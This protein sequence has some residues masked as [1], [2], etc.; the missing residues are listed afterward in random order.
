MPR[1]G[2][3]HPPRLSGPGTFCSRVHSCQSNRSHSFNNIVMKSASHFAVFLSLVTLLPYVAADSSMYIPG[4]D[5]QPVTA[6]EI[7][8]GSDGLTTWLI[9]PGVPSGTIPTDLGFNGPATLAVGPSNANIVY[10]DPTMGLSIQENCA[11]ADGV[12]VCDAIIVDSETTL[13]TV[14]TEQ[15]S[16][17]AVQAAATATPAPSSGQ[18]SPVLTGTAGAG[19]SQPGATSVPSRMTSVPS[20]STPSASAIGS[21]SSSPSHTANGDVRLQSFPLVALA[22]AGLAAA[23]LA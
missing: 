17:F 11:V 21:S 3:S 7:G 18:S 10:V 9:A 22:A 23:F 1:S 2:L 4:F 12:A 19:S 14:I 16:G 20:G 8:V 15:A 5:A 13:S 6:Q